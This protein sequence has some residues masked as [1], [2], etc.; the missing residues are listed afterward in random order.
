FSIVYL[1]RGVFTQGLRNKQP[2]Q[3]LSVVGP[4]GNWFTPERNPNL[5]HLMVAGGV[6]APPLYFLAE[7]LSQLRIA[8][9]G[10]RIA[11]INGA[12]TRDLLVGI[13]EFDSLGIDVQYTTDDGTHGMKG[14][15]TDA[16]IPMLESASESV[17][18]YTC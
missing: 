3:T 17:H 10:L 12:R 6:G 7:R 11:A 1:A 2:G 18:V 8:D 13:E 4:L 14:I 9:C 16:L 5:T 15:V